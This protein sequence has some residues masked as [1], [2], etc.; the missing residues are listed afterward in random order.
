M[1]GRGNNLPC[2][3]SGPFEDGVISRRAVNHKKSYILGYLLWVIPDRHRQHDDIDV[4]AKTK[5]GDITGSPEFQG[6]LLHEPPP[7]P[8]LELLY[9]FW[10]AQPWQFE[11]S[12]DSIPR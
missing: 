3:E 8:R 2:I 5:Y 4:R 7:G 11:T 12:F 6:I 1:V 9:A 10:P